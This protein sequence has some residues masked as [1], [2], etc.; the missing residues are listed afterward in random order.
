MSLYKRAIAWLVTQREPTYLVGGCVRDR[1]L[2]RAITDLDLA[3]DGNGLRLARRLA[4]DLQGSYYTLDRERGTGRAILTSRAGERLVVD[5][6]QLRG[7]DL[8]SDLADRDFTINALAADVRTPEKV[9]DNHGGLADLDAGLIRPVSEGSIRSDPVRALRAIRLAASLEFG[10]AQ[11]TELLIRRDGAGMAD[12][13]GERI[14][15]EFARLLALPQAQAALCQLDD[16][17]VLTTIVPELEPL[18]GI[19]Q[20]PPHHLPVLAHSLAAV[21]ALESLLASVPSA[22][23]DAVSESHISTSETRIPTSSQTR[24]DPLDPFADRIQSHLAQ[25]MSDQRPRVVTLKLAALL[26]DTGKATTRSVDEDGRIRFLGHEGQSERV[27]GRVLRRLRF[28]NG[29]VGMAETV[30]RNHMRPLLLASQESVSSRAIYRFFRD[31]GDSGVDVLL[32]ALADH[33]ATYGPDETGKEWQRL[34]ALTGRMLS[35]Y[36]ER[37][38]GDVAPPRLIGGH[39]LMAEFDVQPGPQI[40]EL[41]DLVR[42][43]Q[44]CGQATTRDEALDLVRR[45]LDASS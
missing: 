32:H 1:L 17:Q 23:K 25:V 20:P 7:R 33:Q 16:L 11:E 41:L 19:A 30:V 6:A 44:I 35:H 38:A 26:H 22:V 9:I 39:D 15:D 24:M 31:T 2:G 5:V 36:Y 13:S 40:G 4:N 43:A 34:L 27:T 10:L 37:Q 42:E 28:S 14:R 12:V 45:H 18:R 8:V 3:V 29:E 21:G